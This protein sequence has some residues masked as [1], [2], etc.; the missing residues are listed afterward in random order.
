MKKGARFMAL[1]M[2]AAMVLGMTG[3]TGAS[4][5]QSA[6]TAKAAEGETAANAEK[7]DAAGEEKPFSGDATVFKLGTWAPR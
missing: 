6:Q 1:A 7:Q 5:S 3:C 4:D 2:S